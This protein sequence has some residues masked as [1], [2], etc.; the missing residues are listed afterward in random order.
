MDRS[1]ICESVAYSPIVPLGLGGT[2]RTHVEKKSSW[3]FLELSLEMAVSGMASV[4][5]FSDY[6]QSEFTFLHEYGASVAMWWPA[7]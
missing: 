6:S 3:S 5:C 1:P 2:A 4:K 7:W